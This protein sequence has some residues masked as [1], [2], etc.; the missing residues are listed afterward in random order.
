MGKKTQ[1]KSRAKHLQKKRRK[2]QQ[3]SNKDSS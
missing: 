3:C 2:K 1:K